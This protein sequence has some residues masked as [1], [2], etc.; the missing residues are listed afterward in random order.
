[1]TANLFKI[2]KKIICF[3]VFFAFSFNALNLQYCFGAVIEP[4]GVSNNKILVLN[5]VLEND[6]LL[7][8]EY[9]R[10]IDS[11]KGTSDKKVIIVKDLHCNKEVQN[12]IVEILLAVGK[13]YQKNFSDIL[14]EG[15]W[16]NLDLSLIKS[17]PDWYGIKN[18][19][20]NRFLDNG[21]FTGAEKYVAFN[22]NKNLIGIENREAYEQNFNTL[23]NSFEKR[24]D[25]NVFIGEL[26]RKIAFYKK[27]IYSQNLR[28]IDEIVFKYRT[29]KI[30]AVEYFEKLKEYSQRAGFLF[31]MEAPTLEKF[32]QSE[33]IKQKI[34]NLKFV[35][36]EAEDLESDLIRSLSKDEFNE[37]SSLRMKN[38][39]KYYFYLQKL[40]LE[41]KL[42]IAN[43]YDVLNMYFDY[44]N[45]SSSIDTTKILQEEKN[46]LF[47]INTFFATR[48]NEKTLLKIEQILDTYYRFV[49]NLA[50]NEETLDIIL[51]N[52]EYI[53]LIKKFVSENSSDIVWLYSLKTS[54]GKFKQAI[55][56]M[57]DFYVGANERNNYFVENILKNVNKPQNGSNNV[58][59]V[60]LGGYHTR[61]VSLMLKDKNISYLVISPN[62]TKNTDNNL[63]DSLLLSQSVTF[64]RNDKLAL[65]SAF[66]NK[67][68]TDEELGKL[69]ETL[70]AGQTQDKLIELAE[71]AK[72]EKAKKGKVL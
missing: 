59:V 46:V 20:V 22:W 18:N 21:V 35:Q 61:D 66:Q 38:N 58:F 42:D 63:Y 5:P 40:C 11:F 57:K 7:G 32:Y 39:S 26:M 45:F 72:K 25:A 34:G 52:E 24:K 10:I 12:N 44:L 68:L 64:E 6:L 4:N 48:T 33:K 71:I 29:S 51:N 31:D 36:M 60:V 2:Y 41:R 47:K 43:K 17:F 55:E 49:N 67:V 3:L 30:T 65:I 13:K 54:F 62:I 14:V 8:V 15:A 9:G 50:L 27:Q 70:T 1:M 28:N 56:I 19:F 53:S 37:L 69:A 23:V 16:D